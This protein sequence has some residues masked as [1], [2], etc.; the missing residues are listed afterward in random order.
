MESK[1]GLDRERSDAA[2]VIVRKASLRK[3][4]AVR[5]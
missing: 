2:N 1:G 3:E 5:M 4:E